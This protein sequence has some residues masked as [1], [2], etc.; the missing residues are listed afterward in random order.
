MDRSLSNALKPVWA[1]TAALAIITLPLQ[2]SA[3]VQGLAEAILIGLCVAGVAAVLSF[4]AWLSLIVMLVRSARQP[5]ARK[6]RR[7]TRRLA[8]FNI[9][10]AVTWTLVGCGLGGVS[11]LWVLLPA[12]GHAVPATIALRRFK[13]RRASTQDHPRYPS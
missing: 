13:N 2:A 12:L 10:L 9:V 5:S 6:T 4:G 11:G 7:W 8:W 3:C 1:L